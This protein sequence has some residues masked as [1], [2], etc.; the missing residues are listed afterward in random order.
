[1]HQISYKT[2]TKTIKDTVVNTHYV[3]QPVKEQIFMFLFPSHQCTSISEEK[4]T[5]LTDNKQI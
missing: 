5:H 2:M 1:M 3:S 4:K